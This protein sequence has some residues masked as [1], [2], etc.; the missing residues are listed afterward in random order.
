MTT[1]QIQELTQK[2]DAAHET[3]L[4]PLRDRLEDMTRRL[5]ESD[6]T[7]AQAR[8][9]NTRIEEGL[10]ALQARTEGMEQ[11]LNRPQPQAAAQ[12]PAG[13]QKFEQRA[14]EPAADVQ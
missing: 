5:A 8:D 1:L 11:R 2:L 14:N 3:Q 6:E 13:W 10:K 7:R 4:K 12:P 9:Q